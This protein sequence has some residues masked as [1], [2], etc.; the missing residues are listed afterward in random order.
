[1]DEGPGSPGADDKRA[2]RL[3]ARDRRKTTPDRADRS[4]VICAALRELDAVVAADRVLVYEAMGSEVDVGEFAAWC[5]SVGKEVAVPEDD[6]AADWADV[7]IVP[8][9]AFTPDGRRLGQ[10]AGWYDRYL[11]HRRSVCVTVGVA[12]STQVVDDLPVE[13]H[14]VTLDM[15]VTD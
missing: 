13:P 11:P 12:F 9:L 8:G 6:V 3:T 1:M 4:A 5:R 2:L 14:D 10:G 7:V 15:V